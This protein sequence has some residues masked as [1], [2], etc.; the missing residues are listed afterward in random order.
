MRLTVFGANGPT[1]RLVVQ[2][3]L[4]LGFAVRAVT[5]HPDSFPALG[6]GLDI[7]EADVF[8]AAAVDRAVA[9]SDAVIS[10]LGVPYSRQPI[11]VYSVGT[12]HIA[13]AMQRQHVRRL[14]CVSSTSTYLVDDPQASWLSHIGVSLVS[15][16]LGRTTYEDMRRMET[17][18]RGSGL[19]WTIA[20]PAGLFTGSVV[21]AYQTAENFLSGRFTARADLAASLLGQAREDR[22]VGK[23][24]VVMTTQN[25]PSFIT[26]FRGEIL[27]QE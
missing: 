21:T 9:G 25:T 15:R 27:K 18:V 6:S 16:T 14:L 8:D 11:R 2:Q 23:V 19:D 20:R 4:A 24:M 17:L 1:G 13:S 5:R 12:N 22:Y 26:W 10:S 3:G 7:V